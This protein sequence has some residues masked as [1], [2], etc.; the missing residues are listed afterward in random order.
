[1]SASAVDYAPK[2][3][4]ACINYTDSVVTI[5]WGAPSDVCGSF[6]EYKLF[7]NENNGPYTQ[8]ATITDISTVEYPH[9]IPNKNAV[10]S[11][12]LSVHNLCNGID[13]AISDTVDVDI[14]YPID[15]Q[16]DSVSYDFVTQ[17]IIAG[18]K[19]NPSVDTKE[20]QIYDY[21]SGNGDS[22]GSTTDTFYTI[23][24]N[25][26]NVFPVVI[27]TLDSCLLT[28]LLSSPHKVMQ[29]NSVLDSCKEEITLSWSSYVGWQQIDSQIVMRS[30]NGSAYQKISSLGGGATSFIDNTFTMGDTLCYFVRAFTEQGTISSSSR[31]VCNP[32]RKLETPGYIYLSRV[33][34]KGISTIEL[35]WT[36]DNLRDQKKFYIY[37]QD[38]DGATIRR[39]VVPIIDNNQLSYQ[40]ENL[41]LNVNGDV[42]RF[43][44]TSVNVCDVESDSSNDSRSMLLRFADPKTYNPYKHHN[45]YIN[46]DG[47][48]K[49]YHL[50]KESR[51]GST[52]NTLRV[53]STPFNN[54]EFKDSLGC[55]RILAIENQNSYGFSK[56]SYSNEEC[57][58]PPLQFYLPNAINTKS[59]NNR[60]IILGEGI[61][62]NVSSYRIYNRWGEM[63]VE[64]K[65]NIPWNATYQGEKVQPGLYSVIAI[66]YGARGEKTMI[67][68]I[69]YVLE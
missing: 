10:R 12:Y 5:T 21:S 4:R 46:W 37:R 40:T 63:L 33:S 62:H 65:T 54:I 42:H 9:S 53:Q 64:N 20:Y 50:Q 2:I 60:F 56:T 48:V 49:E 39:K 26:N 25:P 29:I 14:I 28:S 22:I 1:M 47:G 18:W 51:D 3:K 7:A 6:T 57:V 35:E 19:Q 34:V 67:K 43:V 31:T 55:Y 8:I 36:T 58:I 24:T 13:S 61:D 52:W 68:E 16:L 15:L 30:T 44:L 41:N 38:N 45:P 17:N 59:E 66:I 23:T 27:A 69:I 11:Y 32:T